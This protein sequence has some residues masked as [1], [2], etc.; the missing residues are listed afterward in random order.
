MS[1][2]VWLKPLAIGAVALMLLMVS[3]GHDPAPVAD[4]F[5]D[6]AIA[7]IPG[8]VISGSAGLLTGIAMRS[9]PAG[10]ASTPLYW[11]FYLL[12]TLS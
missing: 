5:K 10:L 12:L 11:G 7:Q 3:L 2:P 9:F 6:F 8:I 4:W 1:E